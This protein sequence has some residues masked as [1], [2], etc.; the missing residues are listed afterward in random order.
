MCAHALPSGRAT[1]RWHQRRSA[2]AFTSSACATA[3][4]SSLD[5]VG[6]Q[7]AQGRVAR[8]LDGWALQAAARPLESRHLAAKRADNELT[9]GRSTL[10][11]LDLGAAQDIVRQ[12]ESRSH[13]GDAAMWLSASL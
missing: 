1:T 9:Q 7:G 5:F 10:D 8:Q 12:V 4:A 6:G 11:G 3:S 2:R 13:G